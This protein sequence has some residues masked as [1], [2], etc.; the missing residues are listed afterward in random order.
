MCPKEKLFFLIPYVPALG[1]GLLLTASFPDVSLYIL[2][3]AALVPLLVSIQS[4]TPKQSFYAGWVTGVCHYMTLI[5]W[6][7]P[8]VTIYGGLH[9]LLGV[10]TLV[11]LCLYLG[12]YVG[13]FTWVLKQLDLPMI[14]MPL[15]GACAWVGLEY[16]RTHALT[17]F[18]WGVL[19]YSQYSNQTLLQTADVTG[20]L[21][22]SFLIVLCNFTLAHLC[23]YLGPRSGSGRISGRS[24]FIVGVY[25]LVFVAF[26]LVYGRVR[27][28]AMDREILASPTPKISVV[29]GN[30]RQDLKWDTTFKQE[31]IETYGSL[32]LGAAEQKPELIIWPETALPFYYGNDPLYSNQVDV[33]V[34][35]AKTHFLVG[36]PAYKRDKES[37]R[38]YNRAYMLN[39][40]SLVTGTYDKTHLVPFGEYVPLEAYLGFLGK[41][42]QQAGNFSAGEKTFAP[43]AFRDHRTGVLICFE[44]L[45]PSVARAFVKNGADVLTTMTNDAWFGHTSAARQHFS[46]AVLRAVEN[47]RSVVRAANTGISGFIDPVGR[48]LE[49]TGLFTTTAIT[50][51]VPALKKISFYTRHGDLI[52]MAALVAICLGFMVKGVN[53]IFRRI[54]K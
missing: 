31:T 52:G 6:I 46:I 50:G 40:L 9:S 47:R 35:K 36:S 38:F 25:T 18:P 13:G 53:N 8:T 49:E 21:G 32:S 54:Q 20:V 45:F 26:A 22:I 24:I 42:T 41:I 15:M 29:Q 30:I 12:L 33:C 44:I 1:S 4:M 5:Y 28:Q 37:P 34:R 51:P 11:L 39:P 2:A 3:F 14:F 43:L 48:I 16:I 17:G 27:I 23:V 10:S 7:V 19:G